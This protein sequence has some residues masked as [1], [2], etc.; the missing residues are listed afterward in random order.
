MNGPYRRILASSFLARRPHVR[1]VQLE[2]TAEDGADLIDLVAVERAVNNYRPIPHLT[3][4]EK[5][6]AAAYLTDTGIGTREIAERLGVTP[7]TA[8]R[9]RV[10]DRQLTTSED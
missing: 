3:Q 4:R 1:V 8:V 2:P 6:I 9:W 7:R 5:R 10:A